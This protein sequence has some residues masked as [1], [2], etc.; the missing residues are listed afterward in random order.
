MTWSIIARDPDTG[1]FGIAIS[2]CAFAVGAICPWARAGSGALSTQAHT[3]PLHGPLA[4]DM[5]ARGISIRDALAMSLDHDQGREIRQVHGI[6]ARGNLF[7][8]TGAE[9]VDWCGHAT[10]ENVTVA[11]NMLAGPDVVS[12]TLSRFKDGAKLDFADRLLSALEAGEAAGGDKRGK[13]S[14]A[15]LIQGDEPYADADLRVDD[16]PEPITEL[17]RLFGIYSRT[18]R[19]YMQTMG[20]TGNFAGIVDHEERERAVKAAGAN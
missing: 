9:C 12:E 8:H 10:G 18:R 6:D 11:G 20:R 1:R 3:N 19:A 13:Q 2:T 15:L 4:L 17:R 5:M 16:N 14:A 7:A